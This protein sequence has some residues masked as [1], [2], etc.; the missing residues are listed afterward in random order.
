MQHHE[1]AYDLYYAVGVSYYYTL[2]TSTA[3]TYSDR[4]TDTESGLNDIKLGVTGR[5]NPFRN[6]RSWQLTAVVPVKKLGLSGDRPGG[7][8]Y[9]L[10]AGIFY[11]FLPDPY[12]NPF[13][14]Y[15]QGIFG[16]GL[17]TSLRGGSASSELWTYGKWEKQVI[18][19][20]W[21]IEITLSALTSY[22]GGASG[23][24]DI[25]GPDD[26]YHYDQLGA[27]VSLHYRLNSTTGIGIG[28]KRDLWGRNINKSEGLSIGL[29]TSWKK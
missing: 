5:I 28:Y 9:A 8:Q 2:F 6:G 23:T 27:N 26:R 19:P 17:G 15:T 4:G 10:D 14:Q 1:I 11:R 21:R 12:Q 29:S 25:G 20:S 18:S 22:A 13:T 16:G 3:W 24:V 7:G